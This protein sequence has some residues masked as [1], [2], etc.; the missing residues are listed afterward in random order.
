MKI[1]SFFFFNTAL[2]CLLLS[3]C[4]SDNDLTDADTKATD[5]TLY[6]GY[7]ADVDTLST[8]TVLDASGSQFWNLTDVISV[9]G[10]ASSK[11]ALPGGNIYAAFTVAASAPFYAMYPASYVNS[12]D[13]VNHIFTIVF[14]SS[15]AYNESAGWSFSNGVNPMVA[16]GSSLYLSFYNVCGILKGEIQAN[17]SNVS[18]VRFLSADKAVAGAASVDP[19]KESLII[20]S[21]YSYSMDV[22]FS[23]A[24]TLSAASP[25][26]VCW[27]L[28]TG[29]Y[30]SGWRIQLL[31]AS[32]N[33]ILQKIFTT[34]L[35]INR[36]SKQNV[37]T[38]IWQ[39]PDTSTPD[40]DGG[41][42]DI[43]LESEL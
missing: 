24:R 7:G 30:G 28:P 3:G 27:V 35:T 31:D 32:N 15:Q 2:F 25:L 5:I 37:G 41:S 36:S 42:D 39:N 40:V 13:N 14:P 1:H 16:T 43:T 38:L 33:V 22:T 21:A 12:Y 26:D 8:R 17:V 20:S 4:N 18:K 10:N 11:T 29:A 34:S 9:N 19:V 6:A 23:T